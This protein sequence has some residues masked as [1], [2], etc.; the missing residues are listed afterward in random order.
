MSVGVGL[1]VHGIQPPVL[2]SQPF[3]GATVTQVRHLLAAQVAAVGL[4]GDA[5]DDFVLAVHELVTNAVRHGG[6]AGQLDLYLRADVLV[7]EVTDHGAGIGDLLVEMPAADVPGGRGLWL[8][9]QLTGTL[10][11]AGGPAGVAAS[12]SACLTV[13]STPVASDSSN[14]ERDRV[15][16]SA[17]EG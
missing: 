7:C 11:V 14:P 16:S 8:A 3:T 15:D 4:S 2:L 9:H 6:G 10:M 12:V 17:D 1:G 13:Q 5:A